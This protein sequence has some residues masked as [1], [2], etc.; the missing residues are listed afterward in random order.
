MRYGEVTRALNLEFRGTDNRVANNMQV[1]SYGRHTAI[2]GISDLDML[3][4]MPASAWDDYKDGGQ[5]KLLKRAADA[6]RSRYSRTK[7]YPDILVVVVEYSNFKIEVQPVFDDGNGHYLYPYTR[8]GGTWR[9]T[10]P[11]PE[12]LATA[13]VDKDKNGNLRRLAKLTRAWKNK[14][15]VAMGG[16]LIDTLAYNYLRTT[17]EF[18]ETSF[19]G[20]A[21]MITGFL[22]YLSNEQDHDRYH[23]LGSGQHVKVHKKFQKKASKGLKIAQD[24]L[25]AG[26]TASANNYWRAL[27]GRAFPVAQTN[28]A[29]SALAK[30]SSSNPMRHEDFVEDI[31]PVDVRYAMRIECE[32]SQSGFRS[33]LMRANKATRLSRFIEKEKNLRFFIGTHTIKGDFKVYWKVLNR[34]SEAIRRDMVRGQIE[35]GTPT[36]IE[37][38]SFRG[39]HV[40]DC[41]AV[42]NG[43]V[44]AKDRIHVPITEG[45]Q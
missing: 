19:G 36:K 24:A 40:V 44:I 3:Y 22:E 6:I 29:E 21:N 20:C 30:S 9:T 33:F 11:R 39:E 25:A 1:G 2:R 38:S 17:D 8:N 10:K 13:D 5:Y 45:S 43:V 28:I 32:V 23:A 26:E 12:L 31:F 15:G 16:L 42:Q 18:D 34:G 41:Y 14:H 27:F 4:V 35:L 37:H 7:V